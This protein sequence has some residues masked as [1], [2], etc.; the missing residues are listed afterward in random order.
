[1]RYQPNERVVYWAHGRKCVT[2]AGVAKLISG[3]GTLNE[4]EV[5]PD[6]EALLEKRRCFLRSTRDSGTLTGTPTGHALERSCAP[7]YN[8]DHRLDPEMTRCKG[9]YHADPRL[10]KY[11]TLLA[12]TAPSFDSLI[13]LWT[14]SIAPCLSSAARLSS[15]QRDDNRAPASSGRF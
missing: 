2:Q 15:N 12:S 7:G 14:P 6:R 9:K 1:M 5:A 10:A 8:W 13:R 11:S 4:S 3:V